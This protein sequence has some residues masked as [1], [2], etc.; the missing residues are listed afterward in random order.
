MGFT[1]EDLKPMPYHSLLW[2]I[3]Q[4]NAMRSSDE[5]G[6]IQ[7]SSKMLASL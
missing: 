5:G 3:H 4:H 2:Y 7:G 6:E 1:V